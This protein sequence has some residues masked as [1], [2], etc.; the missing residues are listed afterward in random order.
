MKATDSP[1]K[2]TEEIQEQPNGIC[3]LELKNRKTQIE[4]SLNV[5][6]QQNGGDRE[7]NQ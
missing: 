2:V 7:K 5:L 3:L 1:G 6:Q 4:S